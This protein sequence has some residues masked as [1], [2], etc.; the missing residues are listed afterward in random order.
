MTYAW[1]Q[2]RKIILEFIKRETWI[3]LETAEK[4]MTFEFTES[5]HLRCQN[6]SRKIV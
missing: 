4:Q 5:D 1:I 6:K 2:N 3:L